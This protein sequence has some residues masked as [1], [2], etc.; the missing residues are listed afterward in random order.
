MATSQTR[1]DR[2]SSFSG[3]QL[4]L[5]RIFF[6]NTDSNNWGTYPSLLEALEKPSNRKGLIRDFFPMLKEV[7]ESHP[8]T[9]NIS[10]FR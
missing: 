3:S 7:V 1:S 5:F 6:L 2:S 8:T 4:R 10:N 9:F